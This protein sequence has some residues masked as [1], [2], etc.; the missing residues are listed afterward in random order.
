[1]INALSIDVED[2]WS[3]F[4]RDWLNIPDA[5]PTD[6]VLKNTRWYLETFN[7]CDVKATFFILGEVAQSFP[8]LI[9]EIASQ[10][11]EIAV[12]GFFHKQIFKL[13]REEFKNEV[14][15]AKK[16]LEDLSGQHVTGHRA[17]AFSINKDTRWALEIL[18][19]LG[20]KYDSSILPMAGKRYG[21]PEFKS[22]IHKMQLP[23]NQSIIEVPMSTI[24][25][26]IKELGVGGGYMRHLPY[27]Y[28]KWA[29]KHIQKKRPAMV[30][31]HPYEIDTEPRIFDTKNLSYKERN[32]V[33]KFHKMQQRNRNTVARKLVKLLNEFEFTTIGEVINKTITD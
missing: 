22:E 23:N 6:T 26:G 18:T 31:I 33:I 11:H 29:I 15:N 14:G 25:F 20:Y 32:R 7:K 10:G 19:E 3:I 17:P 13:S 30:Y 5:K 28:T 12:H 9:E 24:S 21:W 27:L 4:S 1:M 2:Y 16:L 8:E